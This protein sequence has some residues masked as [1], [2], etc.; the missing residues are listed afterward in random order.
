MLSLLRT[1][2]VTAAVQQ[3][4]TDAKRRL[5]R[6]MIQLALCFIAGLLAVGGVVFLMVALH[7]ALAFRFDPLTAKLI[8]GGALV[9]LALIALLIARQPFTPSRIDRARPAAA[10]SVDIAAALGEDIGAALSRNA[11]MLTIGAFVAG[12]VIAARRR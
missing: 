6:G 11:G 7:D 3:S 5:R 12:L 2:L 8:C 1:L 4:A 10:A 9:V